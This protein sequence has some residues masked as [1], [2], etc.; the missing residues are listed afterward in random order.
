MTPKDQEIED[1]AKFYAEQELPESIPVAGCELQIP[2]TSD[3]CVIRTRAGWYGRALDLSDEAKE[4]CDQNLHHKYWVLG[5]G[6]DIIDS[7]YHRETFSLFFSNEDD[8]LLFKM[9]WGWG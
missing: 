2:V 5:N 8:R 4:W 9:A 6:H 3:L 7:K 1:L